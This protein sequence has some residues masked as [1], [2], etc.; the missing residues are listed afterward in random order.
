MDETILT[1]I[2][3]TNAQGHDITKSVKLLRIDSNSP[4]PSKN[5]T[6]PSKIDSATTEGVYICENLDT[7]VSVGAL[8]FFASSTSSIILE[9]TE[10]SNVLVTSN[11]K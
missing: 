5:V 11:S 3:I 2:E 7:K 1:G 8:F 6:N 9:S 4:N 10:L